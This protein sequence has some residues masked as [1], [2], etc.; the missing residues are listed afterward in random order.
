VVSIVAKSFARIHRANLIN[1]GI[2]PLMFETKED[3]DRLE[4]GDRLTIP[5]DLIEPQGRNELLIA[6]WDRPLA[7]INDLSPSELEIIRAGGRLELVRSK[8]AKDGAAGPE[9][10]DA[11]GCS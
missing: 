5:C 4:V 3:F 8:K 9:G 11:S 2:L 1:F 7:V 10:S 6:G